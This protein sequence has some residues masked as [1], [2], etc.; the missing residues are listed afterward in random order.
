MSRRIRGVAV[1]ACAAVVGAIGIT[2]AVA[3]AAERAPAAD[4]LLSRNKP[5]TASSS[6]SCC[7]A[8]N[9]VEGNASTA[10]GMPSQVSVTSNSATVSWGAST[11]DTGVVAYDLFADDSQCGSVDGTVTTGDCAGLSADSDHVITVKAR[12]AAG[13]VSP[14]S[15][16]LTVHTAKGGG[17]NPYGDPNLV[18]M[19]NGTNLNGW[20]PHAA[21]AWSVVGGAIHG[22]GTS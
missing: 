21:G 15:P 3:S 19:F 16:P 8:K 20:T 1:L 18:S 9:A 7:A 4:A 11:D 13:N 6:G 5:V 10:P 14:A 2:A 17:G 12:D 22:N